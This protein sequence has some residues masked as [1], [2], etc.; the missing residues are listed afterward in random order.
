MYQDYEWTVT[1]TQAIE[2]TVKVKNQ[3]GSALI[4][5]HTR[6]VIVYVDSAAQP[7]LRNIEIEAFQLGSSIAQTVPD[8]MQVTDFTRPRLFYVTAFD[9]TEAWTV[10]VQYPQ[11]QRATDATI[12]M[13]APG[14]RRAASLSEGDVAAEYRKAG[15]ETWGTGVLT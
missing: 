15:E 5:P 12:G 2:R 11:C 1:V 3:V 4:D 9:E 7:S 14:L 10:S 8:P 6:N 13:D